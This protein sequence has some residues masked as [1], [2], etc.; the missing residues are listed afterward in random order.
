MKL[1]GLFL[2]LG[3]SMWFIFEALQGLFLKL[4]RFI[5]EARGLLLK[6]GVCF[7]ILI[8]LCRS[9]WGG[10]C[11]NSGGLFLK[12]GGLFLKLG[13]ATEPTAS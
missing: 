3:P 11:L 5:F 12:L 10:L 8:R 2:K 1:G 9:K 7:L 6:L 4:L 13:R